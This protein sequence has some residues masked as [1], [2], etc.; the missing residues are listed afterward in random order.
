[1]DGSESANSLANQRA[2]W[3]L[4]YRRQAASRMQSQQHNIPTL[5]VSLLLLPPSLLLLKNCFHSLACRVAPDV[6]LLQPFTVDFANVQ[7]GKEL[8][9]GAFATVYEAIYTPYVLFYDVILFSKM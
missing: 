4:R 8:G 9:T 3:R 6:T 5:S 2:R 1:M 7:Q